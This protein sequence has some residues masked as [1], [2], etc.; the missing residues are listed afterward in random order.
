MIFS[1]AA[2][3]SAVEE[4]PREATRRGE[5]DLLAEAAKAPSG[6]IGEL[7]DGSV[8]LGLEID[9][10]AGCGYGHLAFFTIPYYTDSSLTYCQLIGVTFS[11]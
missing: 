5:P 2:P 7:D 10:S 11:S 4:E 9:D 8:S 1:G 3:H 6:R